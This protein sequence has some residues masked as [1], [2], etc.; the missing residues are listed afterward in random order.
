MVGSRGAV[1]CVGPAEVRQRK[2]RDLRGYAH[3]NRR[4]VEGVHGLAELGVEA[5][6]R[7][8][9]IAVGVEASERNEEYLPLQPQAERTEMI[10]ATCLSWLARPLL[11][12]TVASVGFAASAS[13]S[14]LLSCNALV[15]VVL[16]AWIKETP[17]S[18]VSRLCSADIRLC[19]SAELPNPESN[20]VGSPLD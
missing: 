6:L 8:E 20:L 1:R 10:C 16:A 15:V 5:V 14:A 11:G 18:N 4:L 12:K 13:A 19:D 9:L 2:R 3:F 17:V 7:G